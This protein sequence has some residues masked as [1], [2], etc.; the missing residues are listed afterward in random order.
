M[1]SIDNMTIQ[2]ELYLTNAVYRE[3]KSVDTIGT[4]L[5]P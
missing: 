4:V 5:V 3:R 2:G 1:M